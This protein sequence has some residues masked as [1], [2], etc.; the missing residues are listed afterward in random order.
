MIDIHTHIMDGID[1]GIQTFDDACNVLIK[2]DQQGITGVFLTP[3]YAPQRGYQPLLETVKDKYKKLKA[4][5]ESEGLSLVVYLG[6]EY[7]ASDDLDLVI[8]RHLTH[9][10]TRY[11]LIDFMHYDGDAN[12]LI[13]T[14]KCLKYQVI[15]AHPERYDASMKRLLE[16]KSEGA[17][18][19][20]NASSLL[21][22]ERR[23][24]YQLAKRLIKHR[25]IDFVA[26]DIHRAT[27]SMDSLKRVHYVIKKMTDGDYADTLLKNNPKKLITPND[28]D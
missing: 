17:L 5:I 23:Q 22:K 27:Q 21:H 15:V 7:D 28:Y 12:E 25:L 8:P 26:S 2:L 1:D 14:L 6:C 18:F 19:Q 4:F 11:V 13:Y 24:E 20:L 3:H 9:N 10:Q 16:L